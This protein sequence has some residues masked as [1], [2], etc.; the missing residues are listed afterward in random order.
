MIGR[1]AGRVTQ[2]IAR[3]A[4][5]STCNLVWASDKKPQPNEQMRLPGRRTTRQ[6]DKERYRKA[7]E[8][9]LLQIK[10]QKTK[11]TAEPK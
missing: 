3:F 6:K 11:E 10:D 7:A 2:S 8:L 9:Y 4:G 1:V 5:L